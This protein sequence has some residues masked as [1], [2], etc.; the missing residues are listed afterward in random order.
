MAPGPEVAMRTATSPA[1]SRAERSTAARPM[2]LVALVIINQDS[3][4]C[5]SRHVA[6][7][8]DHAARST[9]RCTFRRPRRPARSGPDRA[10]APARPLRDEDAVDGVDD[11][12]R[13]AHVGGDDLRRVHE[14]VP[15]ADA[16]ADALA[17]ERLD[18]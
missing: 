6:T 12:V 9:V 3:L 1:S 4:A 7:T 16:D 14:H 5:A 15:P 8:V 18:R 10:G 17:V 2:P 11:P 13:C